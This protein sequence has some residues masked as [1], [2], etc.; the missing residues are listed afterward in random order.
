[1]NCS[2]WGRLQAYI[3]GEIDREQR[4]EIA[5][6]LEQCKECRQAASELKRLE[7]WGQISITESFPISREEIN[8]DVNAAWSRFTRSTQSQTETKNSL[9]KPTI[10]N[11]EPLFEQPI[12]KR[13]WFHMTKPY[14]KWVSAAAVA[15]VVAGS[16]TIPAVQVAASNFLSIFRVDKTEMIKVTNDDLREMEQWFAEGKEG[17]KELAGIGKVKAEGHRSTNYD[18]AAAAKKAGLSVPQAPE[19]YQVSRVE[20]ETN[21]TLTFELDTVKTNK[22]L[23]KL[24]TD[25]QFD[26]SL[27]GKEFS[28]TVPEI[29]RTT[30]A[31]EGD[32]DS[33]H[34]EFMY[35]TSKTP[36][37]QAPSDVNLDELRETVLRLPFIPENVKQ[38]LANIQD[39][40]ETLPIPYME[41]K[42]KEVTIDGAKGI[43]M[44]GD[45][46][47]NLLWQKD[48]NF[49]QV[50][51]WDSSKNA[52]PVEL[53]E[54]TKL[55]KQIQE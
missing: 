52:K 48:G 30:F 2:D 6:H 8:I 31:Q 9:Q 7:E 24:K 34:K 13:S 21:W 12:T 40:K 39:W 41:D 35:A 3:D 20:H 26:D 46:Y 17:S 42:G 25:V 38:Q 5:L 33:K 27:N 32:Q 18:N 16:L 50:N 4:K 53:K 15:A 51:V 54:L 28:I 49:Y 14:A 29:V 22:F 1:M 55:V 19:G 47:A 23:K 37:I 44:S 45:H 43:F 11:Q 36:T 10:L